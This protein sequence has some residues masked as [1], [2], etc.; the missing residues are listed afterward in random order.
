MQAK[1]I[2]QKSQKLPW[3]SKSNFLCCYS[4]KRRL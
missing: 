4:A 2:K 1:I 3:T